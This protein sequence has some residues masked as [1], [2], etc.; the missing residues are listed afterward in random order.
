MANVPQY[1]PTSGALIGYAEEVERA[2]PF[3]GDSGYSYA[4]PI[5][6]L[7]ALG[8][9]TNDARK[10]WEFEQKQRYDLGRAGLTPFGTPTGS[11]QVGGASIP[12]QSL[13]LLGLIG[14]GAVWLLAK[15]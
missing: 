5:L 1:D 3:S 7:L 15:G 9:T 2:D 14:L 11:I 10:R 8:I 6:D 4:R 12:P 13:L